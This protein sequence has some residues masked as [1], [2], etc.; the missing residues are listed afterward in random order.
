MKTV[1]ITGASRGIGSILAKEYAKAGYNVIINYKSNDGAAKKVFGEIEKIGGNSMIFKADV[2]YFP[3]VYNMIEKI[4]EKYK[5]IDVL[6]NNA[7]IET[8]GLLI[9]STPEEFDDVFGVNIKGIYNTTKC[10]LPSMLKAEFGRIINI[11]SIWGE[12]GA[13]CEVIYSASKAAVIGFSKALAKELEM[14]NITVNTIS[15]SY[16]MTDMLKRFSK[17]ELEIM[18]KELPV[19]NLGTPYDIANVALTLSNEN[20]KITGQMISSLNKN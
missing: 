15:P 8:W 3:E 19:G 1:L 16:V 13:S 7:G 4:L 20:S 2:A 11:A 18:K 14:T 17:E 5:K 12:I 10:V 6:I 9:D